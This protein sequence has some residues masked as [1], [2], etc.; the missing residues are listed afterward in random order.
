MIIEQTNTAYSALTSLV[1]I[2][3]EEEDCTEYTGARCNQ[4]GLAVNE[5]EI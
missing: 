1:D 2:T 4:V 5:I 3:M